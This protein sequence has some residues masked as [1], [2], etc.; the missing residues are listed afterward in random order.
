MDYLTIKALHMWC[1]GLSISLFS[2]RGGLQL[3]G[4]DWRRWRLLR[5]APHVVDTVLLSAAIWLAT[6]LQQ[7]PFVHGWITAKVLALIAYILLGR[8]ALKAGQPPR[9]AALAFG[10]ALLCVAYI[11][12]VAI[13]HSASLGLF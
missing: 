4:I 10:G 13:T 8:L 9:R 6:L 7:I 1:A 11:V 2:L 3:A 12:A 5:I